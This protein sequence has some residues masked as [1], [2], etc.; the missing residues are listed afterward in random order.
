EGA[1]PVDVAWQHVDDD[2]PPPSRFVPDLPRPLDNLVARATRRD[3]GGRPTDAGALLAE[4][5]ATREDPTTSARPA[6][7]MAGAAGPGGRPA[8]RAP[9]RAPPPEAPRAGR[10]SGARRPGGA[11]PARPAGRRRAAPQGGLVGWYQNVTSTPRGRQA[12]AASIVA[13]GLLIAIGGWW[14]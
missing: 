8:P 11:Q 7:G 13:L 2:V 10:P 9:S 1:R 4:G 6:R 14:F 3:P 5:Q 12:V